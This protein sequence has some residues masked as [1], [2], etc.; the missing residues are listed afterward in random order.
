MKPILLATDGSPSA[1]AAAQEAV[2]LA[3]ALGAPLLVVS[4]PHLALPPYGGY[5]GYPEIVAEFH[6]AERER[7]GKLL[8]EVKDRALESGLLCETVAPEGQPVAAEVCRVAAERQPRL[9]VI[10]AHGWS[11]IGRLLHGSVSTAVLHEA[12]CPVL[13][14]HGDEPTAANDLVGAK[15]GVAS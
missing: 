1:D 11:R 8:A 13:V 5:V 4:V 2:D 10:G 9:I 12:P 7:V 14:V 15:A 6:D 3:G